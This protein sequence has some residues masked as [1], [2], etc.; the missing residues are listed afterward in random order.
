VTEVAYELLLLI[1]PREKNDVIE[2]LTLMS[3][4]MAQRVLETIEL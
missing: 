4:V 1:S 2:T 3:F